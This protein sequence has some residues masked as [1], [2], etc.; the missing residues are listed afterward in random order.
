MPSEP[1]CDH[2]LVQAILACATNP[3]AVLDTNGRVV[4]ANTE[5]FRRTGLA[6]NDLLSHIS[7]E[8]CAAVR[9]ALSGT[10]AHLGPERV[11]GGSEATWAATARPVDVGGATFVILV[12]LATEA[13]PEIEAAHQ[14]TEVPWQT[15]ADAPSESAALADAI[16]QLP[17]G[18]MLL[19]VSGVEGNPRLLAHNRAYARLRGSP[20]A[21][22]PSTVPP[23]LDSDG[24]VLPL[25]ELPG[26]ATAITG[27]PL[28]ETLVHLNGDDGLRRT[29]LASATPVTTRDGVQRSVCVLLDITDR[30][31][32]E[33]ARRASDQRCSGFFE[34]LHDASSVFEAVRD[35]ARGE[36]D[37]FYREVNDAL[38]RQ[39]GRQRNELV[40]RRIVDLFPEVAVRLVPFLDSVL[41]STTR[42][43][44]REST[45]GERDYLVRA[46]AIG[47][48]EVVVTA[49]DIT[50]R[51]AIER[52]LRA[53]TERFETT[54][55]TVPGALYDYVGTA[56]ERGRFVYLSPGAADIFEMP[57]DA[58]LGPAERF[59]GSVVLEDVGLLADIH[60]PRVGA[61]E[62]VECRIITPSGTKKVL[63]FSWRANS[64]DDDGSVR[65]SGFILDVT[66][67]AA[68]R[69][70]L[71]RS[72]RELTS[73]V[74]RLPVGV[75]L[76]RDG[77]IVYANPELARCC[78]LYCATDLIGVPPSDIFKEPQ[79]AETFSA[80]REW[81][82]LR[83]DGREVVLVTSS[84]R[85]VE[86]EG[87]AAGLVAVTDH[88]EL[89][90]MRSRLMQADRL[91]S[92]G[93][94]AAGVA[95]EVNNPLSFVVASMEAMTEA[96]HSRPVDEDLL[97]QSL[98]DA[99]VGAHRVRQVVRDLKTFSHARLDPERSTPID[100]NLLLDSSS[101][102]V[103]NEIRHRAR[104]V[105]CYGR[106]P[107]VLANE[108]R[109]GQVFL[110]LL[111]NATQA[112]P[113]G[114][115]DT[116][117]IRI[118]T[119]M[120]ADGHACIEVSDTGTGMNQAALDR[121]FEPFFTTKADGLGTGLGLAICRTSVEAMGGTIEASNLPTRGASFRITL[122]CYVPASGPAANPPAAPAPK[123]G[124]RGRVLVVDDEA[125]IARS[126]GRMLGKEHDV[127]T[128][129]DGRDLLVRCRNGERFDVIL[130]DLM[131]PEVTG[132][133][134][135]E[136][137]H[138][139]DPSQAK[140]MVFLTGGAFTAKAAAFLE[141]TEH[142]WIE[143]PYDAERVRSIVRTLV[144]AQTD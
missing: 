126:L 141:K 79:T 131:M 85:E 10:V 61:R 59:W 144:E 25:R 122:P 89:R 24:R 15:L 103:Q 124:K 108:A 34:A 16:D 102:M 41:G 8:G 112:L 32:A 137:L 115:V 104:L 39:L 63:R 12:T 20:G 90:A 76:E 106:P 77:K 54:A 58:L 4:G 38:L 36:H 7:D 67:A 114:H 78:G 87:H 138:S 119:S 13:A 19:E 56:H 139:V 118:A 57:I 27:E 23:V 136:I 49:M 132:M 123:T 28:R 84:R 81:F 53:S 6:G 142:P 127:T 60:A 26:V 128:F 42:T 46:F 83:P 68:T 69:R 101:T 37:W 116:N 17:I 97:T 51:K 5:F 47:A 107:L 1:T 40:G 96:L 73:L 64:I 30:A 125:V 22:L 86:F 134:L 121:I 133:D 130:C 9:T 111:V 55:T 91:A 93:L 44:E 82:Y 33:A 98:A 70:A 113:E 50:E 95:H 99:R 48:C 80:N 43:V 140:K 88:T 35:E 21:N 31:H 92:V 66:D 135:H 74:E 75:F 129:T 109:L 143:K 2:P 11:G 100:V 29:I 105:K 14:A 18:I 65:G 117:V 62:E 3:L 45:Y 72:R 120:T 110:N 71:D 52:A 94:L